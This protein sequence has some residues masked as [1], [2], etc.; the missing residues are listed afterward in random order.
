MICFVEI[1]E[2]VSVNQHMK[3]TDFRV[4]VITPLDEFYKPVLYS[5]K[6]AGKQ[7]KQLDNDIYE[8]KKYVKKV[9]EKKTPK[10]VFV[11]LGIGA[12]LAAIPLTKK[13]F[14]R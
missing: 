13:I 4:G 6:E 8:S 5:D 2:S 9:N 3:N 14:R 12:L 11:F 1:M 10:S 7:F